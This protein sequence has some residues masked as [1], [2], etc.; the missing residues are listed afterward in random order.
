MNHAVVPLHPVATRRSLAIDEQ[1]AGKS[2]MTKID[3]ISQALGRLEEGQTN[4]QNETSFAREQRREILTKLD[5]LSGLPDRVK[6]LEQTVAIHEKWRQ[7]G[8]GIAIVISAIFGFLGLL[9]GTVATIVVSKFM[10]PHTP[11]T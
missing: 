2:L 4:I 8:I 9:V 7:R 10:G 11:P 5:V 6:A 3:E 1:S